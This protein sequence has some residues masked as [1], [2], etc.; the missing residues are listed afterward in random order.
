MLAHNDDAY[1]DSVG[2]AFVAGMLA[3]GTAHETLRL[4][5]Q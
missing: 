3:T 4:R 5:S 1:D 2:D